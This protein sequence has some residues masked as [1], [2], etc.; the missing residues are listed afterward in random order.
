MVI[1]ISK[2]K[3]LLDIIGALSYYCLSLFIP[4][5]KNLWVFGSWKGKNFSD[6]S[7][8]LFEFVSN[9]HKD[10]NAIWIAKN[11]QIYDYVKSLGYK[12]VKYST[13]KGKWLV[14]RAGA[15]IQTE[16]NRDTGTYRVGGARII[17]LFHGYGSIKEAYLYPEMSW[18]KKKLVKIYAENHSNS[19][20]MVPSAYF[21]SR[22][23]I[24]FDMNPQRAFIT[25]QPRID[26]LFEGKVITYFN[27]FKKEHKKMILYAPT[28]RNYAQSSD[29]VFSENDW[30]TINEFCRKRDY[31]L[32]FKPHPL[33]LHKYINTFSNYSNLI[34]LTNNSDLYSSDVYEYMHYFDLMIS[35][36]SSI[37]TDYLVYDRP[38]I[39]F[40]YD[41]D[42]FE[43]KNFTLEAL[44][45][46]QAGPI[47]KTR[48]E[49]FSCIED[50]LGK[51][52]YRDLRLKAR[53]NAFKYVDNKNCER[54][55]NQIV[56]L[57]G[58]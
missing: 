33:E 38:V 22:L 36:Y 57:L 20:W 23:P 7:K 21:I 27:N 55:Y 35:D 12:V 29:L 17:Q 18:L 53:N 37:S 45:A 43:N 8:A 10:I 19:F 51:D 34:L 41:M 44:D 9:N 16:S 5:D 46:F 47:C 56:K 49:L 54:V 39:H 52:S 4:K 40:M 3:I 31:I 1:K 28:H 42:S 50:G 25:G 15:N 58:R 6:N 32:F 2:F 48:E 30:D 24:L 11:Q 13:L 26:V 14:V